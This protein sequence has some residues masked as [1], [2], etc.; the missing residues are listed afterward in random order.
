M[1]KAGAS[2][3]AARV[4]KV[5]RT[6][7]VVPFVE[8]VRHDMERADIHT[9]SEVELIRVETDAG[10]SGW[11]E[12]IQHYTWG[13]VT[14]TDAVVGQSPFAHMWRDDLG[15]GLQ[16]ALFDVAG[17]LAG[18]PVHALLGAQVRDHCPLSFWH[19]DTSPAR[20]E[21]EAR[22]AVELG[23][24]SLKIKTRPW[25]DVH[26]TLRRISDA[27]PDWFRIDTDWNDML[28]DVAH[29]LPVLSALEDEFEK[30]KI[31]EG[32]MRATD[33]PGNQLLRKQLRTPTAHHYGQVPAAVAMGTGSTDRYCDGFVVNGGV[34]AIV[35]AGRGAETAGMPF[36][37]QMVGTG[38][39]AAMCLHL[40]AVLH[41]ARWPAIT[42]HELYE[43]PLLARRIE[44]A[45]GL[46]RVPEA[47][48]L[49][50]DLDGDAV[51]RY[52]VEAADHSL[53]RR[54][55]HFR[56]PTGVSVYCAT[57]GYRSVWWDYFGTGTHPVYE[58]GVST[59]LLADDDSAE[60]ADLYRRATERG[61]VLTTDQGVGQALR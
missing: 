24:T 39:T 2:A 19:H 52:R 41:G 9:W 45:G 26:E 47:S 3:E 31:F 6:T 28:I 34:S 44:V 51:E 13:R 42:C 15:A 30:I 46:A 16:M 4:N 49:G 27:T 61:P 22:V 21:H 43:H 50:V 59:E 17:K 55:I 7:L 48:G 11:G 25:W 8:R 38:L 14:D 23:Y 37:L 53:P 33:V 35:E 20:Y 40:G 54:L 29:A 32:P 12:T 57:G 1:S 5:E 56:R 10:V 60:F 18:V 58:R 36:F